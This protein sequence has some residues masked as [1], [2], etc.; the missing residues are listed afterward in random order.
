MGNGKIIN[1]SGNKNNVKGLYKALKIINNMKI[2]KERKMNFQ[3]Y[4]FILLL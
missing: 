3:C 2:K 1:N 4:Y